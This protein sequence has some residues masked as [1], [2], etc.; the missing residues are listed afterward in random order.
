MDQDEKRATKIVRG[1]KEL[2][3]WKYGNIEGMGECFYDDKKPMGNFYVIDYDDSGVIALK[4]DNLSNEEKRLHVNHI[5]NLI[6]TDHDNEASDD[7]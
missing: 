5:N 3:R 7:W 6:A 4:W 1:W 2:P